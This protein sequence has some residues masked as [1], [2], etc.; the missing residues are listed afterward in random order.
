MSLTAQTTEPMTLERVES[1]V[2]GVRN[3]QISEARAVAIL[4]GSC[5]AFEVTAFVVTDLR[6]A[7]ATDTLIQ[8]LNDACVDR[9][10]VASVTIE[11]ARSIMELGSRLDFALRIVGSDGAA[12]ED[13]PVVWSS[14]DDQVASVTRAGTVSARS[15]GL[16]EVSA[17]AEGQRALAQVR[18][19]PPTYSSAGVLATGILLPGAGQFRVRR[20]IRGVLTVLGTAG[21][22]AW[23]YGKEETTQF[24]LSPVGQDGTCPPSDVL[25][26]EVGRPNLVPGIAVGFALM[27]LSAIDASAHARSENAEA[28]RLRADPF[29]SDAGLDVDVEPDGAVTTSWRI[30][31]R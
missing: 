27:V 7:G 25:R 19:L 20:P 8:A 31:V 6:Q 5:I 22:I 17:E 23:G 21:A 9:P 12:L 24:C 26:E 30:R 1:L 28:A 15:P 14:T 3:G 10:S 16:V 18:V 29:G 4:G 11:P 2:G 13:R